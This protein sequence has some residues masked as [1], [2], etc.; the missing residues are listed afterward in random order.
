MTP[1]DIAEAE[2]I[3]DRI[4]GAGDKEALALVKS[5]EM[6]AIVALENRPGC[7]VFRVQI[8]GLASIHQKQN[9]GKDPEA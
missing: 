2:R 9:F 1:E 3:K 7:A 4:R 5:E 6:D 8:Q